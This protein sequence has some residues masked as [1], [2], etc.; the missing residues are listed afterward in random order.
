MATFDEAAGAASR[1]GNPHRKIPHPRFGDLD[2]LLAGIE[3]ALA[4]D[5][6]VGGAALVELFYLSEMDRYGMVSA[7]KYLDEAHGYPLKNFRIEI[8]RCV[9]AVRTR[10]DKG[11]VPAD[12]H[13]QML[14]QLGIAKD[15]R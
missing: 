3:S 7:D 4:T 5:R 1:A 6:P 8:N 9:A 10:L 2:G 13:P 15:R 11:E 14:K 12:W